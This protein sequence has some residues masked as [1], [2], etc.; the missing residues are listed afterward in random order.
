MEQL[1]EPRLPQQGL[2]SGVSGGAQV[3]S[4]KLIITIAPG[5]SVSVRSLTRL[6]R[7]ME[8]GAVALLCLVSVFLVIG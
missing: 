3:E 4:Q 5:G 7:L 8:I 1:F 2:G 6:E